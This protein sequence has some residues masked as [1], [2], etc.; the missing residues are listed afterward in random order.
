MKKILKTAVA[1]LLVFALLFCMTSCGNDDTLNVEPNSALDGITYEQF[2]SSAEEVRVS[3]TY[4]LSDGSEFKVVSL[5]D[6]SAI[7]SPIAAVFS[8]VISV[9]SM[10]FGGVITTPG[11]VTPGKGNRFVE[12]KLKYTNHT[13]SE[14][15]IGS[16]FSLCFAE[17]EESVYNCSMYRPSFGDLSAAYY[18]TVKP[19]KS[20]TILIVM[21]AP[22]DE[23]KSGK[24][25]TVAFS[26][27]ENTYKIPFSK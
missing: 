23:I 7:Y 18:D 5:K 3:N 15:V 26:A 11:Y 24:V 16:V 6:R 25:F 8:V 21:S 20:V 17:A 9:L 12:L 19:G 13:S 2:L 22:K 14:Q 10:F 4:S 27:N 1:V